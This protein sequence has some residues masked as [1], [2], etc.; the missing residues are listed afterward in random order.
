[1]HL[2]FSQDIESL[3]KRLANQPLTLRDIL[4]ETSERGFSLTIGLLVLPF[5]FPMPPGAS[6]VLGLGCL[7][8]SVQM[9]L[10]RRTPWLPRKVASFQFPRSLSLQLLKNL[11]RVM[12]LLEKIVRP[13]WLK[14]AESPK[15]WRWNGFCIAW[16]TVL[17]MLPFP[18][19]N[20]FP[21]AVILLLA[22]ATLEGDGVLMCVG[23]GLM[24]LVTLFF[25]FIAYALLQAPNLLP[26]FF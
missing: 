21:T 7:V 23:Y 4:A 22:V 15:I 13:R 24:A 11:K 8:L 25:C 14:V 12:R 3:L 5:L 2:K 26:N 20:P 1:M 17:L 16:L 6:S 9:A 19:T 10:G 18:F